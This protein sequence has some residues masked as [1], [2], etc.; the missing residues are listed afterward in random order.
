[1]ARN[2]KKITYEDIPKEEN[3]M[4]KSL[5][6][7]NSIVEYPIPFY[8]FDKRKKLIHISTFQPVKKVPAFRKEAGIKL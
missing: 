1:M 5:Q 7:T 3:M 2:R 4:Q 6:A 8:R